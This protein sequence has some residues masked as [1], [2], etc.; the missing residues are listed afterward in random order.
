MI[1]GEHVKAARKLLKWSLE[2]LAERATLSKKALELFEDGQ[3]NLPTLQVNVL[4][5]VLSVAGVQFPSL[6]RPGVVLRK[7]K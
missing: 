7:E 1:T 6:D 3:A 4:R 2:E 5:D